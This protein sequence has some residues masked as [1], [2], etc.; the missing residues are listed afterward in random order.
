MA[1]SEGHDP[2]VSPVTGERLDHLGL[3]TAN[4][5]ARAAVASMSDTVLSAAR[6]PIRRLR[7]DCW[8]LVTVAGVEPAASGFG[9]L[10]SIRLSY[11]I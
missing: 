10:R 5:L 7:A 9:D 8:A 1:V 6:F 2:S 4:L 3:P 11:T